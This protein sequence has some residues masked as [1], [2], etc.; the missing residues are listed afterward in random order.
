MSEPKEREY[1]RLP[2]G[3]RNGPHKPGA[4]RPRSALTKMPDPQIPPL[5][6]RQIAFD[7]HGLWW[8][9]E[10]GQKAEPLSLEQMAG[11]I[12]PSWI[13]EL[14]PVQ[15]AVRSFW[16]A[17]LPFHEGGRGRVAGFARV[18]G[19]SSGAIGPALAGKADIHWNSF[20]RA[21]VRWNETKPKLYFNRKRCRVAAWREMVHQAGI[22]HCTDDST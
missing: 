15:E 3:H 20:H 1:F 2:R 19:L 4:G 21:L 11:G 12:Q 9:I 14:S 16:L 6:R 8:D 5:C 17:A 22:G 7:E 13:P 10:T 18:V